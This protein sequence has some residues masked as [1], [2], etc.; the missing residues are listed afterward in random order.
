MTPRSLG[1]LPPCRGADRVDEDRI[2]EATD[3]ND[4][5]DK[6]G[7]RDVFNIR[8]PAPRSPLLSGEVIV[9]HEQ[10][11]RIRESELP[12]LRTLLDCHTQPCPTEGSTEG[13]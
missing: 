9:F 13:E 10:D 3:L 5:I 12:M 2:E 4:L 11:E 7:Q 8:L 6:D 1:Q